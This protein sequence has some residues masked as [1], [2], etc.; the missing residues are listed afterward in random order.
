MHFLCHG[1][2]QSPH[3]KRIDQC[4][5]RENF[6]ALTSAFVSAIV[7]FFELFASLQTLVP[8]L[9]AINLEARLSAPRIC[10]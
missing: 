6:S 1:E 3:Q 5:T 9:N 7:N 8:R 2:C 10:F 4:Q